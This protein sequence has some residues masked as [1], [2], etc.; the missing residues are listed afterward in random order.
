MADYTKQVLDLLAKNNCYFVRRGKGSH[1][2]WFSPITNRLF[3]V[4]AKIENRHTANGKLKDAG[5]STKV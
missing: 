4:V 3:A 2:M 1:S 5:I